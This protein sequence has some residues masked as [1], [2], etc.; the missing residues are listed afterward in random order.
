L[1]LKLVGLEDQAPSG[2]DTLPVERALKSLGNDRGKYLAAFVYILGRVARADST[3][4]PEEGAEVLRLIREESGLPEPQARIVLELAQRRGDTEETVDRLVSGQFSRLAVRE[5]K[6]GLVNCLFAVAAAEGK[7]SA[8]EEEMI[9]RIAD[10]IDLTDRDFV[11]V[12]Y[13]YL[14]QLSGHRAKATWP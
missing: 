12:R 5:Q 9:K 10:E 7:I 8:L 13:R 4:S 11:S 1:I 2:E 3:F 6:L 14:K